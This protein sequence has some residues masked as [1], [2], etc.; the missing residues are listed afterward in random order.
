[1][2]CGWLWMALVPSD[3]SASDVQWACA[4]SLADRVIGRGGVC[5]SKNE[6]RRWLYISQGPKAV[7]TRLSVISVGTDASESSSALLH[8]QHYGDSVY[9]L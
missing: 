1:M 9:H 8:V 7:W 4:G 5:T 6:M 2:L 3:G